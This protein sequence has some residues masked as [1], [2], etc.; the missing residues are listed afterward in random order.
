MGNLT[1][2]I[3]E[4][5]DAIYTAISQNDTDSLLVSV[6]QE[7]LEE[8]YDTYTIPD[9][10]KKLNIMSISGDKC[11]VCKEYDAV[12]VI[13]PCD[14]RCLCNRCAVSL[15]MRSIS[16]CPVKNCNKKIKEIV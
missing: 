7:N 12:H 5:D 2:S 13:R 3:F 8:N 15:P 6:I 9:E 4:K 16:N 14:H 11:V 10:N 1:S